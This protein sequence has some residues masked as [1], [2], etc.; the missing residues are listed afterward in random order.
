MDET[1]INLLDEKCEKIEH[2]PGLKTHLFPHQ[3]TIVKAM[4]DLENNTVLPYVDGTK[5][6]RTF[7]G[8]LSEPV[9]SGKTL[10]VL[11]VILLQNTKLYI[12]GMHMDNL[13]WFKKFKHV[14]TPTLI[15]V[16]SSVIDQ[17]SH[18]IEQF[19]ELKF[20]VVA[21]MHTLTEFI[22]MVHN[23]K[24]NMYNVVLVKNGTI[25]RIPNNFYRC[26]NYKTNEPLGRIYDVHDSCT[27]LQKHYIYTI[28]ASMC[29]VC[30]SRVVIDDFDVIRLPQDSKIINSSFTWYISSTVKSRPVRSNTMR[31]IK[32]T[33]TLLLYQSSSCLDILKTEQIY[34]NFNIR[35]KME[36]IQQSN[37]LSTP[38]CL[39][40]VVPN[41]DNVLIN[42]LSGLG[43]PDINIITD[44]LNANAIADASERVGIKAS[45][46]VDIFEHILGKQYV[47]FK[48]SVEILNFIK[49]QKFITF[50][51]LPEPPEES[52]Y[53][54][55]N[56]I[57]LEPI[58]YNYPNIVQFLNRY[59]EKYEEI[60]KASSS[61]I[62]RVRGNLLDGECPICLDDLTDEKEDIII[63]KCCNIVVCGKCC[64]G[65]V[66]KK[67]TDNVSCANCRS[68]LSVKDL[69]YLNN[70]DFKYDNLLN[71]FDEKNVSSVVLSSK[72]DTLCEKKTTETE[73]TKIS[74]IMG[75]LNSD[76]NGQEIKLNVKNMMVGPG[77][78]ETS[79]AKKVL[80]FGNYDGPLEELVAVA[81]N[82]G[83][84]TLF[85]KGTHK[86]LTHIANKFNESEK[87]C[88]LFINSMQHCSGLN[89]QTA[90]ELIFMHYIADSNVETQVIGRAQRLNRQNRL[91]VHYV[92]YENELTCMNAK[93]SGN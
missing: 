66:F 28:I 36:F 53:K 64:F 1:K 71:Q 37:K 9:G 3:Q 78:D 46:V 44:M 50:S 30:W 74:S 58:E 29:N 45:S 43:I 76:H 31:N 24:I 2:V 61:I 40:H 57:A 15:V 13:I 12:T 90:T 65:V 14:M 59:E 60:K 48:S 47:L 55:I 38:L 49:S 11:S 27:F 23:K 32:D 77:R 42:A 73:V 79:S 84:A 85:L 70:L 21:N 20:F 82:L 4:V 54:K 6:I 62:E 89:L 41:K 91:Q 86:Q 19:T 18:A 25:A 7:S 83:F 56:L 33:S 92:V 5:K 93:E 8:V 87:N 51:N 16:S 22:N 68:S 17:W 52:S 26:Y 39:V 67:I 72:T 75:I 80:I 69:V 63:F 34:N 88:I 81:S 10:E 35:N